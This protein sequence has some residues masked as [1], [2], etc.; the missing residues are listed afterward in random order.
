MNGWLPIVLIVLTP[1][2]FVLAATGYVLIAN[3]VERRRAAADRDFI[4][5]ER[6]TRP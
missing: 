2:W 6:Y 3:A 5:W 1:V 4:R